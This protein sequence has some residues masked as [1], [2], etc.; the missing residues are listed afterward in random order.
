MS[1]LPKKQFVTVIRFFVNVPV[2]SEQMVVA[3]PIVSQAAKYFT[4][5][6]NLDIFC[7]ATA[8]ARV[9]ARGKPSGIATT[10]IVTA[11]TKRDDLRWINTSIKCHTKE[12]IIP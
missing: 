10:R 9:T 8:N 7:W 6:F 12:G 5:L 2:L 3:L 1:E 11:V 4:M